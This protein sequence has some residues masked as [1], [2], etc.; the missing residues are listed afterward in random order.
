MRLTSPPDPDCTDLIGL[1]R[2]QALERPEQGYSFRQRSGLTRLTFSQLDRQARALALR[3]RLAY[4]EARSAI[5]CFPPG[6]QFLVGLFGSFYAG[7]TAVPAYPPRARR[8]DSRL[9]AIA[10]DSPA[11]IVL[12]TSD[13]LRDKDR[14]AAETPRL[15]ALP[16][17]DAGSDDAATSNGY[18][19]CELPRDRP[20]VLQYTSGS[21]AVPK[22]VMLTQA[23]ILHNLRCMRDV[24]GLTAAHRAVSWLP[25][26]HD[27]GLIGN[28]L[29]GVFTGID[30][31]LL[32]PAAVAQD[33]LCWLEAISDHKAYVSG[34]P[35]FAFQHCVDR[36]K[37]ADRDRLDLRSWRVAYIGAEPVSAAVLQR[38][39]D[40]FA[41]CGFRPEAFFPT[42]GLAE[43]TL[44]VTGGNRDQP[45]L[46]RRFGPASL[47]TGQPIPDEDG[48]AVVA[49][50]R[51]L[52][53]MDLCIV[54][55][56]TTQP[57]APG[58]I[59]EIWVAGPSVAAGYWNRTQETA[60]TFGTF[61]ADG[62]GPYLRTGDLGFL[63]DELFI[64]GRLKELII[65]RGRNYHPHDLEEA[66]TGLPELRN[67]RGAA[68]TVDEGCRP[69]L[70]M[71]HEVVRGFQ[72]DESADLFAARAANHRGQLRPGTPH[73]RPR[74]HWITAARHQRQNSAR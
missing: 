15:R 46:V 18:E 33:P 51:P 10:G 22:G 72:P 37:P 73:P 71:L 74:A 43:G 14:L 21:T 65:V 36:I 40:Y 50:G 32:S 30:I 2:R 63:Q 4:P 35:G 55:P 1:L 56:A 12:T 47:E 23:C 70:V 8:P 69:Q 68:F 20:A 45:P 59:G 57:A 61:R 16:W 31:T 39:T 58:D 3:V 62:R 38:F 44:M 27:M 24:L 54:D 19:P 34:G 28:L 64:T 42:Y 49:C 25:A 7:I 5:L 53:D 11:A 9:E 26:F 17:L 41:P 67:Q 52:P 29:Q 6:V 13:M 66:V 60:Q 48:R